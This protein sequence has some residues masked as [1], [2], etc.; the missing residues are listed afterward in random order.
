[1]RPFLER[2]KDLVQGLQPPVVKHVCSTKIGGYRT[3]ATHSLLFELQ[4]RERKAS[5]PS[6]RSP[7]TVVQAVQLGVSRQHARLR[8]VCSEFRMPDS[9]RIVSIGT[10]TVPLTS[11]WYAGLGVAAETY[12]RACVADTAPLY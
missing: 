1:M 5:L 11:S 12:V 9:D 8:F 4:C 3:V 2:I 7:K 10:I 6:T